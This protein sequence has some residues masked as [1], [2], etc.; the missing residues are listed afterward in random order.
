MTKSSDKLR[1]VL[2]DDEQHAIVLV[3]KLL[4]L[5]DNNVEI[6]GEAN[7]LPSAIQLINELKPDAV[8]MDIDMPNYSGLQIQDFFNEH[9]SFKLV[10]ITAHSE[11][12]IEALKIQAFDYLL[13]P[14]EIEQLSKCI[15]RLNVDKSRVLHAKIDP[16]QATIT[17]KK[18][19]INSHKGINYIELVDVLYIEASGMYSV[20]HTSKDQTIVSKPLK[21]FEFLEASGFFRIH[22]S[23][24]VNT[25]EVKKLNKIDCHEVELKNGASVPIARTK[26]EEFI[27]YMKTVFES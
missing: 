1:V 8:F 5:F 26:K 2:V 7:Q 17:D 25:K 10:Y 21:D 9:R 3:K 19:A 24:L 4:T 6:V 20:I 15:E 22:R 18:I 27:R 12:A 11:Y 14:V 13:K 23:Y 16:S